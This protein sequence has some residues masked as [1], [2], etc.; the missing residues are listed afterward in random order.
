[1]SEIYTGMDLGTNSIKIVVAEKINDK[2]HVLAAVSSPSKGIKNGFIED[3]KSAIASI[4]VALKKVEET[5]G[6]KIMKV[7]A[8]IPTTNC[9][10]D[11][12]T[13]SVAIVN[14]NEITGTDVSNVL[15]ESLKNQDFSEREL[16][17][18]M[19][20]HFTIDGNTNVKDP[21]GMKGSTL[22]VRAVV[23]TVPKEELYHLLEVLK[24]SGVETVDIAFNSV[25]DYYTIKNRKYDDLVGAIINIGESTTS[26]SVFNKGIMIKNG[27]LPVGS[28]NVDKDITYAF[29]SKSEDSRKIKETFALALSSYADEEEIYTLHFDK[30]T[31]KEVN[32]VTASKVVEARV[33]EILKLAK[34]DI[35][36]LTNREIRYIIVTGGLTELSGFSYLVEQEYG[37]VAK[38]CDNQM[39]GVRHNEFSSCYGIVKYF[40]DKLQLRGKQYEMIS[41]ENQQALQTMD[42][43]LSKE[44][45]LHKVF[46]HF[47]EH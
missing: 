32:Q 47:F 14:Y 45:L 41:K 10:M 39:M 42:S 17:T 20:I 37:F 31:T 6:F 15:L 18:A 4:K 8:C 11:I 16:V 2:F 33:R 34:N 40:D 23:S 27:I 35:K 12:V 28:N 1:M 46:G 38:V 19:P 5:L 43:S 3:N 24:Q 36:N 21:K 9:C 13:G 7:I 25:G 22:E 44:N 29:K 30:D 26:V